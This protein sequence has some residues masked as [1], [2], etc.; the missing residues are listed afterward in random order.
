MSEITL[1]LAGESAAAERAAVALETALGGA[2]NGVRRLPPKELPE[3]T[4][5]VVDPISLAAHWCWLFPARWWRRSTSLTESVASESGRPNWWKRRSAFATNS[6]SKPSSSMPK[7]S[8][9]PSRTMPTR[10]P[11]SL[12]PSSAPGWQGPASEHDLNAMPI[13]L[14]CSGGHVSLLCV[15]TGFE[16]RRRVDASALVP[17]PAR[18]AAARALGDE[19]GCWSP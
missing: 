17:L 18:Y 12:M 5:R 6:A 4:R 10:C 13:R 1:V 15:T 16:R 8:R 2:E 9:S 7:V 11:I 19:A 3:I 14:V